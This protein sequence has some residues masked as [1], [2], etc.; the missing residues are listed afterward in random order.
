MLGG[1]GGALTP[2][3][4]LA[5][6]RQGAGAVSWQPATLA[7]LVFVLGGG[8]AWYELSRPPARVVSLVA[9]LSALAAVGR[10]AFAAIPNVKPTTDIVAVRRLGAGRRARLRGR[11]AGRA[12]VELLLRA[13]PVDPVADDRRGARWAC[14]AALLGA[15][16]AR[17]E[18]GRLTLARLRGGRVRL[19]R[20]ARPLPGHLRRQ[21]SLASSGDAGHRAALRHRPRGGQLRFALAFGPAF[22][23]ALRASGAAS[24]CAGSPGRWRRSAGARPHGGPH[25]GARRAAASRPSSARSPTCEGPERRRRLRRS[26]APVFE[27]AV[28]G[29]GGARPGGRGREPARRAAAQAHADQL[30]ALARERPERHRRAGAHH[31][32]AARL[33]ALRAQLR[34]P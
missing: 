30:H 27:L 4:G 20:A 31:P 3:Q 23:R 17:R 24:R 29:L 15:P 26:A 19:R 21:H 11:R 9:T 1:A 12:R 6:P 28:H 32:R 10:L 14:S 33:G 5:L 18:P 13:G 16:P 22:L 2:E 34:P 7:L 8:L 25:L